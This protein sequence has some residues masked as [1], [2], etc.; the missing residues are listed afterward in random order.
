VELAETMVLQPFTLNLSFYNNNAVASVGSGAKK[1][2]FPGKT[3]AS[4][5]NNYPSKPWYAIND[6]WLAQIRLKLSSLKQTL[7]KEENKTLTLVQEG[8][9]NIDKNLRELKL[10]RSRI[11]PMAKSALDVASKGYE[12]DSLPFAEVI[13][14]Y[15]YWLNVKLIIAKKL[16]NL[17][18]SIA[19]LERVTGKS[20]NRNNL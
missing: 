9:Y 16:K 5:K 17:G 1:K 3:M 6:P 20:F 4:M 10:Y 2:T 15:T 11:L 13:D 19:K 18:I 12:S 14:S 7:I 8:W